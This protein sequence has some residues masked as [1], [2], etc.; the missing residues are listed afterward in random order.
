MP[1][2]P[3]IADFVKSQRIQR[4][5]RVTMRPVSVKAALVWDPT[6]KR[7]RERLKKRLL[8]GVKQDLEKLGIAK[9]VAQNRRQQW[10]RRGVVMAGR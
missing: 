6:G 9:R 5:G 2:V 3:G 10:W 8:D 1:G 4:F 7:A